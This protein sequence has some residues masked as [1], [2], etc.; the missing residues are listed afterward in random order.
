MTKVR[1]SERGDWGRSRGLGDDRE[2]RSGLLG[3][4]A[5]GK[6]GLGCWRRWSDCEEECYRRGQC[7]HYVQ[8]GGQRRCLHLMATRTS[9]SSQRV[10]IWTS[11][12]G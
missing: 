12:E 5:A 3:I 2:M 7:C 8:G 6:G 10:Y 9:V 1:G 4:K 11:A